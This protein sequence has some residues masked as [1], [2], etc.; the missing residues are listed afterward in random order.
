MLV[1]G[2]FECDTERDW[3]YKEELFTYSQVEEH[4]TPNHMDMNVKLG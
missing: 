1:L 2:R 4:V 3:N